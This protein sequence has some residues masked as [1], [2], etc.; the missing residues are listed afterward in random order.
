MVTAA[1]KLK[2]ACSLEEN[3][4]NRDN[5]LKSRDITLPTEVRLVK[6]LIFPVVIYGCELDWKK[7]DCFWTVVLEKT[8]ESLVLQEYPTSPS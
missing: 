4:D 2:D 5:I 1:I 6:A 7:A 3:Y 8:R